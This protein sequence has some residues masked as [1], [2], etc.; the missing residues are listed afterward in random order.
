M[1]KILY[2]QIQRVLET[3]ALAESQAATVQATMRKQ[4]IFW[5]LDYEYTQDDIA[6]VANKVRFMQRLAQRRREGANN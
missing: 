5:G 1:E 4:H 3:L 6:R 2:R